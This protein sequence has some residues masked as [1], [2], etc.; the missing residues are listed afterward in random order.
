MVDSRLSIPLSSGGGEIVLLLTFVPARDALKVQAAISQLLRRD[1][2]AEA[3][4]V[5][6]PPFNGTHG[7]KDAW[8]LPAWNGDDDEAAAWI[9]GV[10][11]PNQRN[12]LVRLVA[13]GI[14]GVWTGELRRM[15]G[16]EESASIGGVFKALSG[17]FRSTG[18]RPVWDGG[19]KDSQKGQR[20]RVLE[21]NAHTLFVRVIKQTY[22]ALA[23]EVGID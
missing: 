7:P 15:S 23:A 5:Y 14:E 8:E 3:R 22:P 11:G 10:I 9:L 4:G 2:D 20:L 17:R 18:F 1:R 12:V 19:E 13:G 16:Y 21:E 6:K